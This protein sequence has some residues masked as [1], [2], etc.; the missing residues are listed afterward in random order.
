[1]PQAWN[2]PS[3]FRFPIRRP[4]VHSARPLAPFTPQAVPHIS[5]P[6]RYPSEE[7]SFWEQGGRSVLMVSST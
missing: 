7:N 6:R 4:P 5:T 1:M 3:A 2:A